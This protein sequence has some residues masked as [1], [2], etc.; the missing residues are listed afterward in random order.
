MNWHKH[1]ELDGEHAFLSPSKYHWLNYTDEKLRLSYQR[2]LATLRGTELHAYAEQAIRLKRR[3]PRNSDTVN[4]YINDAIGLGMR[5]EQPLMYSGNCFGT[6]DAIAFDEKRRMLRIHDLKTGEIPA[7]MEQ[8]KIYAALFFLEYAN[9]LGLKDLH[10]VQI[11]LRIYQSGEILVENPSSEEIE[12]IMDKIM[13][14][15]E[16]ICDER[17]KVGA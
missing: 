15:D 13:D 12:I 2:H 10:D 1:S 7:H 11:E 8:L 14:S 4:M 3:Q 16:T 6:A 5:P 9:D 17:R